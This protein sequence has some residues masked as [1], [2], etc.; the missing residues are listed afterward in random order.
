LPSTICVSSIEQPESPASS[1]KPDRLG[2]IVGRV[3]KAVL[4]IAGDRQRGRPDDIF[5]VLQRFLAR[6]MAHVRPAEREGKARARGRKRLGT[7]RGH[8]SRRTHIPG[9]RD[10]EASRLVKS[11]KGVMAFSEHDRPPRFL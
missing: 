4:E 1:G 3:G 10:D 2:D 7:R 8:H 5:G 11:M 9:V 6:H